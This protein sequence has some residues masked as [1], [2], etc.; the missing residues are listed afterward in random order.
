ML[1]IKYDEALI[2]KL[3]VEPGDVIVLRVPGRVPQATTE[4]IGAL[5]S[6]T[7]PDNKSVLLTDGCELSVVKP[8]G[9]GDA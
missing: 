6:D 5:M 4:R 8:L 3:S 9:G 7:F 1:E 2:S